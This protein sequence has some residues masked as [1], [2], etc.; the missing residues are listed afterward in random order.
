[1]LFRSSQNIPQEL[2]IEELHYVHHNFAFFF[3]QANDFAR[4]IA[5]LLDLLELE[6]RN[7]GKDHGDVLQT[8]YWIGRYFQESQDFEAAL[9]VYETLLPD[10]ER[11]L[12]ENG[13]HAS[14]TRFRIAECLHALGD[15]THSKEIL[16]FLV[17]SLAA[18]DWAIAHPD[19]KEEL[20]RLVEQALHTLSEE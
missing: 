1:M 4:A 13:L 11:V 19:N 16:S 15:H 14:Y 18:A 10:Q 9:D 12:S 3:G 5:Q 6:L 8:R 7:H 2:S 20:E 17:G